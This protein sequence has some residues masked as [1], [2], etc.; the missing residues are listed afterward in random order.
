MNDGIGRLSY[1][2]A[3][4]ITACLNLDRVPTCFQGRLG[5]AKGIWII[6]VESYDLDETDWIETYPSQ[7]KWKC[8][9]DDV[10]HRTLEIRSWPKE[11][12][13]ASLNQQFIPILEAQAKD[14]QEMRRCIADHLVNSLR[15]G[16]CAQT[17]AMESS[18]DCRLWMQQAGFISNERQS[19]G[20]V[21][22]LGGLPREDEEAIA[23]LLDSGF[24]IDKVQILKDMFWKIRVK[25]AET[26][27][28]K[29]NVEIP[30]SVNAYMVI[31]FTGTL[32]EN[33]VQL[34]FS[35]EF[36]AE[37]HSETLLDGVDV[38][39]ARSPA[40]FVSDIQ[41]VR[42]VFKPNLR[43]LKNVIVFSSK[44]TRPLADKLSGGDYDGDQAWVCW[45]PKLVNN[46]TN[47]DVP[48]TPDLKSLGYIRSFNQ[49]FEEVLKDSSIK[50]AYAEFIYKAMSFSMQP[51]MLGICTAYKERFCYDVNDVKHENAVI[52]S[53]LAGLLVDQSKQGTMFN[54]EDFDRLRSDFKMDRRL[55]AP[56]YKNEKSRD[57][58]TRSPGKV[59]IL[60]HLKFEIAT[61]TIQETLADFWN[62]ISLPTVQMW[63]ADL[64]ALFNDYDRQRSS[65]RTIEKL[66]AQLRIAVEDI[67]GIWTKKMAKNTKDDS[68]YGSKVREIHDKWLQISPP[69][70]LLGS[71]AV[72]ML[73]DSWNGDPG[74]SKWSLL[75]AST[76]FKY[77]HRKSYKAVWTIAGRQLA[78]M[79]AI[80]S[81]RTGNSAITITGEM[82]N[83][84]RPNAKLIKSFAMRRKAEVDENES[85]LAIEEVTEF[86]DDGTQIDDA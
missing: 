65:S 10:H 24:E 42:A 71:K 68:D 23:F 35:T 1:S 80:A 79:K 69:K 39:V 66:M 8:A 12:K 21:P 51:P 44:G 64:A 31:D 86:D 53:T 25:Q 29:M 82:W 43:H 54:Q 37:G 84:L 49:S 41:K 7:R 55:K 16:L 75:K 33:E 17:V 72:S 13:K 3:R 57:F 46:F 36:L 85:V 63:D 74:L 28:T 32:E 52:L 11:L 67:G 38:L 26:L 78:H 45:D 2:L 60:D 83:V 4:K 81:G 40:H 56:E 15:E 47:A 22:F 18:M 9:Y 58:Q 50:D 6:D 5:S 48:S 14:Q 70:E 20:F 77:C 73:L 34:A 27:K 76:F 30:R 19:R 61:M 59:H 62:S